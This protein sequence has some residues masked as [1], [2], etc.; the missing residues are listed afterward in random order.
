[1]EIPG[2]DFFALSEAGASIPVTFSY[3]YS[4]WRRFMRRMVCVRSSLAAEEKT[5]G[6]SFPKLPNV[7]ETDTTDVLPDA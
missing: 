7:S 1:M 2:I 4:T 6:A 3:P 5:I